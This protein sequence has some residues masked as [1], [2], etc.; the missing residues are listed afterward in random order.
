MNLV[1]VKIE[2]IFLIPA[3]PLNVALTPIILAAAFI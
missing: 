3:S 2:V 1:L